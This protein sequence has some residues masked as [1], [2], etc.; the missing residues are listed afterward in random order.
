MGPRGPGNFFPDILVLK[1]GNPV[2]AL[3]IGD[4]PLG[5][6]VNVFLAA[7]LQVRDYMA[8]K[9]VEVDASDSVY[10]ATEKITSNNVGCVVVTENDDIA[11][12][13]TKGDII[14]RALMKLLDPKITRVSTI[15]TIPVVTISPDDSLEDAARTMSSRQVSK[16]PV[17]DDETGLLVGI[18]TSTD[19]IR[20]EPGYVGYLKDLIFSKSSHQRSDAD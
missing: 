14:K 7:T 3:I 4:A 10:D 1:L 13:V 2:H 9:V 18:I 20:V 8:M 12:I 19:I 15:M 17:I 16:L 11:G 6:E 5:R